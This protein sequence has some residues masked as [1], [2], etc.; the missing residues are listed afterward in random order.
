MKASEST[1]R[2]DKI[3]FRAVQDFNLMPSHALT[4]FEIEKYYKNEPKFNV[5]YSR[6]NLAK[7][8]DRAYT[9]NLDEFK[10]IRAPSITLYVNDNNVT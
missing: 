2:A 8:K 4:N 5:I 1:I 6:N 7:I 10:S 9:I 3:T